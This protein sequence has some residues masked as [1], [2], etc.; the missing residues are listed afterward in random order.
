MRIYWDE[1]RRTLELMCETSEEAKVLRRAMQATNVDNE[2]PFN[3]FRV[4]DWD[5]PSSLPTLRLGPV[6]K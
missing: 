5:G 3:D 1:R 4:L 6:N 2:L